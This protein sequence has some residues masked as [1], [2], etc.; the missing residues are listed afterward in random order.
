MV[1]LDYSA[2]TPVNK[3]VLESFNNVCMNYI[4]NPNS[5][6]NLGVESNNLIKTATAQIKQ[7]L[8]LSNQEIIYTSGSS[9]SNNLAIKGVCLKYQKRGKHIITTEF[10]HS[11]VYGPL[12]YLQSL[13]FEVDFAKTDE[14]GVVDVQS[15][16]EMITDDTILVCIA[17]V[18]SEIG[19]IQPI[20]DIAKLLKNY[21]KCYLHVDM[22]QSISKIKISLKDIDFISFS[23]HKFFGLKGIGCLIKNEKVSI[24]P[25]IHGGKSTSLFR[26]GTPPTPLI[27]S[28]AKALRLAIIDYENRLKIV[29]RLNKNLREYFTTFENVSINSNEYCSPY[30]LNISVLGIKPETFM[31]TLEKKG[32]YISTQTACSANSS[33]SRAVFALTDDLKRANSS[34]RISLSYLTTDEEIEIFMRE[35]RNV[36]ND[37]SYLRR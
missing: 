24:E 20:E 6:H 3:E 26:S 27:V 29:E 34:L 36:Y 22:T 19:I 18:N 13:G 5:L 17:S 31:H 9:E 37:L 30:I 28:I 23:A 15:L 25:L 7:L 10:E 11:S 12:S 2:T 14:F 4:G 8:D 32:I 1:Y 33:K 21:P 16:K 35:F